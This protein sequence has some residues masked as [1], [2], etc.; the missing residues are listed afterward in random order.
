M[1]RLHPKFGRVKKNGKQ[2]QE[3]WHFISLKR[4]RLKEIWQNV[5]MYF[6]WVLETQIF[7]IVLPVFL[8]YPVS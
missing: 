1:G 7:K 4:K 6:V 3:L 8:V 2:S 5:N